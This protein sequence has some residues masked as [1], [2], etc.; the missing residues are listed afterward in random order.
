MEGLTFNEWQKHIAEELEKNYRKLK[1][2]RD[3]PRSAKKFF[4]RSKE[5]RGNGSAFQRAGSETTA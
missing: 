4:G 5:C 1:L 3:E 2:V